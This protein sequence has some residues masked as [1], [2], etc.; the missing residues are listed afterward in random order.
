MENE[1]RSAE[2][3]LDLVKKQLDT[4]IEENDSVAETFNSQGQV[5]MGMNFLTKSTAY[6][7]MKQFIDVNENKK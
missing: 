1:K 4:W 3:V 7:N 2:E 5:H 6:R